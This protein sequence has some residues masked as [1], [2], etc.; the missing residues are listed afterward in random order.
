MPNIQFLSAENEIQKL[1]SRLG[2]VVPVGDLSTGKEPAVQPL[3]TS[4]TQT[5]VTASFNVMTGADLTAMSYTVNDGEAQSITPTKGVVTVTLTDLEY[6]SGP[7]AIKLTATN[8]TGSTNVTSTVALQHYTNW[9][10]PDEVL[11]GN[12]YIG[13]DGQEHT[14]EYEC[15]TCPEPV[16]ET[17][18]V[19]PTTSA[20]TITPSTG[21]DGIG[22]VNVS[23]VTS[24][25]DA[26]ITAGNIKN[27]VTILGVTGTMPAGPSTGGAVV[28]SANIIDDGGYEIHVTFSTMPE[29]DPA[30]H[31]YTGMLLAYCNGNF[32][33]VFNGVSTYQNI[34]GEVTSFTIDSVNSEIS[35]FDVYTPKDSEGNDLSEANGYIL[36]FEDGYDN[37]KYKIPCTIVNT[38]II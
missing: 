20:Q 8:E 35:F 7:Y 11:L 38:T 5:S 21:Y 13:E 27:G 14:G 36:I 28:T 12:K 24:A 4:S 17:V 29:L 31:V 32:G 26:N 19:T 22:T 2:L 37:L 10:T 30:N 25:I 6:N 34:T 15:P 9:A 3:S 23:A 33:S 1:Y 18:P 16:L